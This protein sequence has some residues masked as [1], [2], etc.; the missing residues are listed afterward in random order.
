M[1]PRAK[2]G[3][4]LWACGTEPGAPLLGDFMEKVFETL[5]CNQD[6]LQERFS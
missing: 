4:A 1:S 6:L 2:D 3:Q 5:V